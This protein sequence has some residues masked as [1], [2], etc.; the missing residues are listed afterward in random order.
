MRCV[1]LFN[2]HCSSSY[3]LY[4]VLKISGVKPGGSAYLNTMWT[5]L[6]KFRKCPCH[7]R[8]T[9][10]EQFQLYTNPF[11]SARSLNYLIAFL[12]LQP[13][14][15]VFFCSHT[16]HILG[17]AGKACISAVHGKKPNCSNLIWQFWKKNLG[18]KNL[19]KSITLLIYCYKL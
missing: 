4:K 16:L 7:S 14:S 1:I 18:I 12:T 3:T 6:E 19:K 9:L 17:I 15:T 5:L 2:E 11:L 13:H 10:V 8:W